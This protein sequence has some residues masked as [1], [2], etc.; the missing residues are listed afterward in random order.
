MHF[1]HIVFQNLNHELTSLVSLLASQILPYFRALES[2][3]SNG[4]NRR[5]LSPFILELL[6]K[7]SDARTFWMGYL[8]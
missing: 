2:V 5:P 8:L 7:H 4:E 6:R 1:G 3:V